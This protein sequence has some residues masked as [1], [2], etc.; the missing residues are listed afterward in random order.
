[1]TD[2]LTRT[3]ASAAVAGSAWRYLLGTLVTS[4]PV[5]SVAQALEV[6]QAAVA[7]CGQDADGH[8]R[9]D[10]RS[11][12]V[13]LSLQT[14][15]LADLTVVDVDLSRRISDAVAALALT[16]AAVAIDGRRRSVQTG[17]RR[18]PD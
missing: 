1:V 10:L 3:D 6:A 18:V 15:V 11:G 13:E 16:I 5:D 12:R 7:A 17:L 9:V 8:L 14:A 4:V 2:T